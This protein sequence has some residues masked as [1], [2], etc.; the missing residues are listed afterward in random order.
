MT[1]GLP[2][3]VVA[4]CLLPMGQAFAARISTHVST[5]TKDGETSSSVTFSEASCEE[6]CHIATLVCKATGG[7]GIVLADVDAKAA[8]KAIV[9]ERNQLVLRVGPKAFDYVI[10]EMDYM[11]MTGSWWLTAD[12]QGSAAGEIAKAIASAK[13]LDVQAGGKKVPL[14]VDKTVKAWAAACK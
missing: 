4:L 13:E 2:L 3:L 14:P 6:E 11:E 9:Q 12:E 10:R 1:K 5:E 7:I 8:A